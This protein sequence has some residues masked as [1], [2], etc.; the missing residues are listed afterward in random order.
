MRLKG[1]AIGSGYQ[2]KER[3]DVVLSG[4]TPVSVSDC[5]LGYSSASFV[6]LNVTA[7]CRHLLSAR[8]SFSKHCIERLPTLSIGK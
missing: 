5:N 8:I 7:G 1:S 6:W 3:F 4:K 2:G